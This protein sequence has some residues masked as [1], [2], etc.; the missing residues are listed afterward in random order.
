M[1]SFELYH[2][3]ISIDM[4]SFKYDLFIDFFSIFI[5]FSINPCEKKYVKSKK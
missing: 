3:I 2:M 4:I 1:I 5:R